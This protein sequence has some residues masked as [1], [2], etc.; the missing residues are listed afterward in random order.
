MSLNLTLKKTLA[1]FSEEVSLTAGEELLVIFGPSGAGKSLLLKMIAGLVKPDE[2]SITVCGQ[3]VFDSTAAVNVPIRKRRAGYLFQ[4][5]ALFPHMTVAGNISYAVS[6]LS[7]ESA[8][9]RTAQLVSLMRLNGLE[10]RYPRELSGGQ[11]QRTALA[12]TL[13]AG[14]EVLLL[15]EPFSALDYQVREK[16][17]ADLVNIHSVFPITTLVVTH[18]LE[19][20][21]T[22]GSRIA[23]LNNGRV[24]HFGSRED[25]FYRP[26]TRNVAR[27]V[28]TRNIFDGRI[29][30]VDETSVTVKCPELGLIR[31][32][33]E[34][35]FRKNAGDAAC[36]CI[37][38]EEIP[39]I[40]PGRPVD[41]GVHDN[42]IEGDI[43]SALP[44]GTTHTLYLKVSDAKG[45]LKVEVPNFVFKKLALTPGGRIKVSL[46]KE[47]VWVIP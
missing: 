33:K 16:L 43:I 47:S 22:L 42:I 10:A 5:Y 8:A 45:D 14:P 12:R 28:G 29:T 25:V 6:G 11:K 2:G 3:K 41:R 1:G 26:R 34:A 39:V 21:F 35:N 27:F 44:R 40:R 20:A 15:D 24:E 31:A 30:E 23:V 17:R 18:D 37:R 36:F 4:D 9:Q 38:P 46:K 19:E 32:H 7:K 13:A